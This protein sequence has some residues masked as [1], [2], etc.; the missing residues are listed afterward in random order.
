MAI[1]FTIYSNSFNNGDTLPNN[2]VYNGH[3]CSGLNVS[4]EL[5]WQGVPDGTKAFALVSHDPDAPVQGGWYH[6]IVLNIPV[7]KTSFKEGEKIVPPM[8]ETITSFKETGYGG[9]CPPVGHGVHHYNFTVYALS[10]EIDG[11]VKNLAPAQIMDKIKAV[12]IKSST[13]TAIY[14][15]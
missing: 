5:H 10:N 9:A 1:D 14:Q 12:E 13:I 4:P 8:I 11:S 2:Q 3:G 7:S 15:R 6:W